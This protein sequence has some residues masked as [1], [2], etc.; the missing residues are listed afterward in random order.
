M[1]LELIQQPRQVILEIGVGLR[2]RIVRPKTPEAFGK[3]LADT[4]T[5]GIAA[6]VSKARFDPGR[7]CDGVRVEIKTRQAERRARRPVG[8]A[9]RDVGPRRKTVRRLRSPHARSLTA[10]MQV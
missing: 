5:H 4:A 7:T 10:P 6:L 1:W 2:Q 8:A 9:R 3:C